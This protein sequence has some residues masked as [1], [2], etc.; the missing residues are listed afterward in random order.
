M[1]SIRQPPPPRCGANRSSLVLLL[2][3]T[4]GL[5]MIAS[6]GAQTPQIPT[7]TQEELASHLMTY[8]SPIYPATAQSAQVQGDVVIKVEI[9]PCPASAGNGEG[10]LSLR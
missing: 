8:V 6:V 2:I 9:S 5:V 10:V 1:A 7:V 3:F 4:V